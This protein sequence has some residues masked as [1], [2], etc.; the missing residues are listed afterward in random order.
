MTCKMFHKG[1]YYITFKRGFEDCKKDV[2][3]TIDKLFETD[4]LRISLSDDEDPTFLCVLTITRMDYED[5]KKQQGLLVDFDNF[6]SQLVR[7][8]QQCAS[9]NMFLIMQQK[10]PV[11]YYLE[12]IEHNEFKRL[13]HLS[14]KTGPATDADIKHHMADTIML[15]KKN[16]AAVKSSAISNEALLND[17][18]LNFERKIHDLTHACARL[19]E[20]KLKSETEL[21]EA[22][23]K[24][25]QMM[26]QEKLVWQQNAD[27]NLKSQLTVLQDSLNSKDKQID[28]VNAVCRQLRDNN[29][30]LENQLSEKTQCL[31]MLEKEVQKSHIEVATLKAKYAS[32][33][34][35]LME[36]EKQYNQ[37]N[38]KCVYLEKTAKENSD[39]I[40]DLNSSLQL[41]KKE[42]TSLEERLALSESLGN[43]N[44]DAIHSISEQLLKANQIISKQNTD[45]IEMKEKL[46]CRT[47][48]A[49]EQEK[50]IERNNQEMEE[51]KSRNITINECMEKLQKELDDLKDKLDATEKTLKDR[52]ETIKNNNMVIQ[53]LHKKLD[54]VEPGDVA[55]NKQRLGIQTATSSTPYFL[56]RNHNHTESSHGGILSEESIDFYAT[57]KS[58][59]L[60]DSPGPEVQ[61]KMSK[62]GLDPKYLQP[63]ESD[64]QSARGSKA[65]PNNPLGQPGKENAN[66]NLP[67]V[68]YREK[69][70]ARGS[71][72]R[73]TPVSAYF[74]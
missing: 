5:L 44:N 74:P 62:V 58:T 20:A 49:L 38:S 17:K 6:P 22:L 25:K 48:I 60:E 72:Y 66:I 30:R 47:A 61:E 46:L 39:V 65:K 68:N 21:R 63:S 28:E 53:W 52:E 71:T 36:K 29:S 41:A 69:K 10:N 73:A 15:L 70:S 26:M 12:V 13:V 1:K 56:S 14:L 7:L 33:E 42:K 11:Q 45:L 9:N 64:K 55:Q 57:S 3:V 27:I 67:K 32:L 50:V 51:L 59:N 35:D 8:L 34:R 23:E 31:N 40:K 43:K 2:T 19:E 16:L 54:N 37:L 4:T 24:E 18:C